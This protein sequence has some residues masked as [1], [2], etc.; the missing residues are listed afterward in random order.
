MRG[1]YRR[2]QELHARKRSVPTDRVG[3]VDNAYLYCGGTRLASRLG[4]PRISCFLAVPPSEYRNST[5]KLAT[6]L[7]FHIVIQF[8]VHEPKSFDVVYGTVAF[9]A[10]DAFLKMSH[11][12]G[13]V[14]RHVI[15]APFFLIIWNSAHKVRL[16]CTSIFIPEDGRNIF[17]LILHHDPSS[18]LSQAAPAPL[19]NSVMDVLR[20]K[21]RMDTTN[22]GRYFSWWS[23]VTPGKC[24][25]T[26]D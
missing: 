23:S 17:L 19:L 13:Q 1:K 11:N 6:T 20:S 9:Y 15:L 26:S 24:C 2:Q 10:R 12:S 21:R 14:L 25:T 16:P 18:R 22:C 7:S 4:P 8:T 5:L 3:S